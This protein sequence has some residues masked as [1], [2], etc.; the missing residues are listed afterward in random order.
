[1][2]IDQEA[3]SETALH[4]VDSVHKLLFSQLLLR[5]HHDRRTSTRACAPSP[6]KTL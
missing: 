4:I 5:W 2:T 1:V 3:S 6:A